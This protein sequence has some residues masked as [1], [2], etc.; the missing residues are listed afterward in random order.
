MNRTSTLTLVL[1]IGLLGGGII[2]HYLLP[3]PVFAQSDGPVLIPA[4][5]QHVAL[6]TESGTK[7]GDL[8]LNQGTIKL[9]PIVKLRLSKTNNK[10]NLELSAGDNSN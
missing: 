8:D 7:L 2:S 1:A 6:I 4:S 9:S 5:P 3:I 10:V